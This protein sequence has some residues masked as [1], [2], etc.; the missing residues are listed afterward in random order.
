MNSPKPE[1]FSDVDPDSIT[2]LLGVYLGYVRMKIHLMNGQLSKDDVEFVSQFVDENGNPSPEGMIQAIINATF[3]VVSL[4][5]TI[6]KD[7]HQTYPDEYKEHSPEERMKQ[8][9][10]S[11]SSIPRP[12]NV[13]NMLFQFYTAI[14]FATWA[15]MSTNDDIRKI[16]SGPNDESFLSNSHLFLEQV[17]STAR[18][19]G[20]IE[21]LRE[22]LGG[23]E[24]SAFDE[25]AKE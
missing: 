3:T 20:M 24:L 4:G 25:F 17:V 8:P 5:A 12:K 21:F 23:N 16:A 11:G 14:D 13:W 2:E 9:D 22:K 18:D 6:F 19:A 10:L 1:K 7:I 15:D